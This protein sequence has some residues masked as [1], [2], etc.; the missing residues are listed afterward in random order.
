MSNL[1]KILVVG[2]LSAT[3]LG[4]ATIGKEGPRID[5]MRQRVKQ[6][7]EL[8][9]GW[10]DLVRRAAQAEIEAADIRGVDLNKMCEV[11]DEDSLGR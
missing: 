1:R 7:V 9:C 10:P 5:R 11:R 3:F 4:C 6:A 8:V 2:I